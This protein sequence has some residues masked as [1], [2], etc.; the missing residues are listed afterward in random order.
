MSGKVETT[1]NTFPTSTVS[2]CVNELFDLQQSPHIGS[3]PLYI[4]IDDMSTSRRAFCFEGTANVK[5]LPLQQ[6]SQSSRAV[7]DAR[8]SLFQL[9]AVYY[10]S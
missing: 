3:Y 6:L 10:I 4:L 9:E 1:S 7:N 5:L 2:V 8:H